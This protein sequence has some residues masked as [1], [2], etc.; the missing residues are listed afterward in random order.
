MSEGDEHVSEAYQI[1]KWSNA[2]SN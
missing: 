1:K 2:T